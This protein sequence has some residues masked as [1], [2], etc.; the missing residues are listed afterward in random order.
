MND[1]PPPKTSPLMK[2]YTSSDSSLKEH[3]STEMVEEKKDEGND[4]ENDG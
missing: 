3:V 2:L 1:P 4:E